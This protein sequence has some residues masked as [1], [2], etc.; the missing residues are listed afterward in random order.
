MIA[1]FIPVLVLL[2]SFEAFASRA[3]SQALSNSFHL[4][5]ATQTYNNPLYALYLS[6]QIV[7]ESGLTTP[8]TQTDNAEAFVLRRLS[9]S[10]KLLFSLGHSPQL[11]F[12]GRQFINAVSS[13]GFRQP[14]NPA[15]LGYLVKAAD[16]AHAFV[17]DT[18]QFNNKATGQSEKSLL[19]TYGLELGRW[20]F[21]G[22]V[23]AENISEVPG[24]KF[25]GTG[26]LKLGVYYGADTTHFFFTYGRSQIK[27]F[28]NDTLRD[29]HQIQNFAF[30]LVDSTVRRANEFFWGL[31]VKSVKADCLDTVSALSCK[32]SANRVTLPVW[33]GIE[34]EASSFLKLRASFTQT[35]IFNIQKD[36]VGYPA[37]A[38]EGGEGAVSEYTSGPNSTAVNMGLGWMPAPRLTLDGLLS[39]ATTQTVNSTNFLSQVSLTYNY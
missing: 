18:S 23:A 29:S 20:H 9:F 24:Q 7:L 25:N 37:Q 32:Q 4:L 31:Q 10:D 6:D 26:S 5:D 14:Q 27:T 28:S 39:A 34:A 22:E 30:A 2:F 19:L 17:V 15:R 1:L 38:F 12:E 13:A 21:V 36:S 3:R 33:F 11:I 16:L 8:T 35:A